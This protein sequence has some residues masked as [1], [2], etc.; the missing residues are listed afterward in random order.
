[1]TKWVHLKEWGG[2]EVAPNVRPYEVLADIER[3]DTHGPVGQEL[4][5]SAREFA[6]LINGLGVSK[7]LTTALQLVRAALEIAGHF[8]E[9]P[10]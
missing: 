8:A 3:L 2:V 4:Q 1:M 6:G 7:E 9:K 10:T 5:R